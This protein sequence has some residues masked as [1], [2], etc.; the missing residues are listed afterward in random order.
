MQTATN[1]N[2]ALRVVYYLDREC[3]RE[4][5]FRWHIHTECACL[6]RYGLGMTHNVKRCIRE[7]ALIA[8]FIVTC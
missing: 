5:C 8:S 6:L 1:L 7:S 2:G 4:D 3:T